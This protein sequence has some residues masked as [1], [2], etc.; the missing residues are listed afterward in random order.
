MGIGSVL[1][2]KMNQVWHRHHRSWI[3]FT[4]ELEKGFPLRPST[5]LLSYFYDAKGDNLFRRIM[6]LPEYYLSAAEFEIFKYQST[7]II[8]RAIPDEPVQIIE[9]VRA[10]APRPSCC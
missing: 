5:F 8:R 3:S 7:E 1:V 4:E 10:T 9:S 6:H 2:T